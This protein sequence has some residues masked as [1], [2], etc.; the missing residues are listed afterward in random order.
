M[1]SNLFNQNKSRRSEGFTILGKIF[2]GKKIEGP[3][4][5]VFYQLFEQYVNYNITEEQYIIHIKLY[6]VKY[7]RYLQAFNYILPRVCQRQD[8]KYNLQVRS[9]LM[10]HINQNFGQI[11]S[12]YVHNSELTL[13]DFI[14]D[15]NKQIKLQ[16]RHILVNKL[17]EEMVKH[18][19]F[20]KLPNHIGVYFS[21]YLNRYLNDPEYTLP[22][23]LYQMENKHESIKKHNPNYSV[24]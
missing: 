24:E 15:Y 17:L 19:D 9:Q 20:Q 4:T 18:P 11:I 14:T 7:D 21:N 3:F 1:F 2:Y 12:R 6:K 16:D 10:P 13:E 23:L 5:Q 22:E 8:I